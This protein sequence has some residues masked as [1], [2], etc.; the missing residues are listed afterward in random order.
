M[1]LYF[2]YGKESG[3]WGSKIS[4]LAEVAKQE[5]YDVDSVDYRQSMDPEWRVQRLLEAVGSAQEPVVLVG[6]SMGAYVSTVAAKQL[7]LSGLF[8]LAPAFYLPAYA[9]QNPQPPSCAVSIVHGWHDEV[10][11]VENV[12]RF[13]QKYHCSLHMIDSD[14]GL[15]DS[16]KTLGELFRLFLGEIKD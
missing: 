6:S 12:I 1:K 15:N 10:V 3:P 13:A 2:S 11:P 8:L 4:Y 14:H 16:L 9:E 7:N 5:G